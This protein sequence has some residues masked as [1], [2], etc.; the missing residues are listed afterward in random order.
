MLLLLLFIIVLI[1]LFLNNN[2]ENYDGRI[3]Q[4]NNIE[5]CADIASSLYDVSAFGFDISGN[6]YVSK[7]SL[8]KPPIQI[9]P[10]HKNF[11]ISDI[12]CNK[13][14]FIRNNDDLRDR[15]NVISNR[16][17]YCYMN[18]QSLKDQNSEL[19]YFQKNKQAK[20]I[21]RE[22]VSNLPTDKE[23]MFKIDWAVNRKELSDIDITFN[24]NNIKNIT[25]EPAIYTKIKKDNPYEVYENDL[26]FK[27]SYP[28]C[29][30]IN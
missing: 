9:H 27:N 29:T 30:I 15:K 19:I 12:I 10:Y 1:I 25:W 17:Y 18:N 4:I 26:D 11:K 7:K 3:R 21:N 13:V 16:L 24:N 22:D 5:K 20:K 23:T 14:N 2:I 6:C 28:K 8:S